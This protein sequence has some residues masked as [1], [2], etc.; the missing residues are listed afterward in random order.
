MGKAP[1]PYSGEEYIYFKDENGEEWPV[2]KELI[3]KQP[4]GEISIC[5]CPTIPMQPIKQTKWKHILIGLAY[6]SP[7]WIAA[8]FVLWAV[9]KSVG[10]W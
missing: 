4:P 9:G 6:S 3:E 10:W 8:G 5:D 1:N 2:L 7:I